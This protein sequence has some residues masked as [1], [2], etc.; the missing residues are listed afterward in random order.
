MR[1]WPSPLG[2]VMLVL[3]L[4][5]GGMAH[6]AER[7]TCIPVSA[8]DTGHFDGDGDQVPSDSQEGVSHHHMGCSGH[9]VTAPDHAPEI[10]FARST[11]PLPL[12]RHGAGASS[13]EP[14]RQLRPPI[15]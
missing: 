14:D 9:H 15:A 1:H 6:A 7:F 2:V 5:T 12:V 4:W 13:L 3:M 10:T 8:E 11:E